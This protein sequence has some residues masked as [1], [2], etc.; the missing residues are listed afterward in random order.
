MLLRFAKL[1]EAQKPTQIPKL[2]N[3]PHLHELLQKVRANFCLLPC[4]TSR[5]IVQKNLFKWTFLSWVDFRADFPPVKTGVSAFPW[6]KLQS[7]EFTKFWRCFWRVTGRESDF[8]GAFGYSLDFPEFTPTAPEVPRRLPGCC[9]DLPRGQ[10]LSPGSLTPLDDSQ[11]ANRGLPDTENRAELKVTHLRWQSPISGFLRL[12]AKIFYVLRKSAVFLWFPAPSKCLN[13]Q[14]KGWICENLRFS[15][16]SSVPL[17]V[18]WENPS[19]IGFTV[20]RRGIETMVSDSG[21]GRGQT[22]GY[23]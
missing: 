17:G 10:P 5:E 21:L 12:S 16:N 20:L 15:A 1:R 23:G 4:N 8:P 14:E 22:I 9:P 2:P 18:P 13:F 7:K 19:C 6:D 11:S 3:T